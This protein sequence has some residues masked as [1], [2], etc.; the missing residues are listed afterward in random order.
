M[1]ITI[2]PNTHNVYT[3]KRLG[4][5]SDSDRRKTIEMEKIKSMNKTKTIEQWHDWLERTM[6]KMPKSNTRF[7]SI[8]INSFSE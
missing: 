8:Y 5:N 1:N 3:N 7:D 4:T 6:S 2:P